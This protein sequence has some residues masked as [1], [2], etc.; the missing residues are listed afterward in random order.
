MYVIGKRLEDTEFFNLVVEDENFADWVKNRLSSDN[1]V[2]EDK[3]SN[4]ES[5]KTDVGVSYKNGK[6][7]LLRSVIHS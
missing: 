4:L 7:K 3:L 5:L 6:M 1:E 2:L